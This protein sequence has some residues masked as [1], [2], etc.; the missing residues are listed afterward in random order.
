LGIPQTPSAL[1]EQLN[2]RLREIKN[3]TH[4]Q[5]D[6]LREKDPS[7]LDDEDSPFNVFGQ[8]R[9]ARQ[10]L[11]MRCEQFAKQREAFQ[12]GR[13]ELYWLHRVFTAEIDE[14]WAQLER[15]ELKR[16][17]SLLH[18]ISRRFNSLLPKAVYSS[19]SLRDSS[20]AIS[21]ELIKQSEKNLEILQM[22]ALLKAENERLEKKLLESSIAIENSVAAGELA[23]FES[24]I[25]G[26]QYAPSRLPDGPPIQGSDFGLPVLE[27]LRTNRKSLEKELKK[28]QEDVIQLRRSLSQGID[29][30]QSSG[31]KTDAKHHLANCNQ[32]IAKHT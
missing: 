13:V 25:L 12:E 11:K 18:E 30:L 20:G 5:L 24:Q 1:R 2:E 16:K 4:L 7:L 28:I 21:I 9:E 6:L 32:I 27:R 10:K 23:Y 26:E 31:S 15:E 8:L 19:P 17:E 22:T 29:A 3:W 14:L